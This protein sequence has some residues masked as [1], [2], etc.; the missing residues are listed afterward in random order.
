MADA[1]KSIFNKKATEKLRNPDDLDKY[2]RV[3]NPSV[4]VIL[5]ACVALLVG[6]LTWGMFGAV[7]TDVSTF[8]VVVDDKAVCFLSLDDISQVSVGDSATVGGE[9]LKVGDVSALPLSKNE[10]N[11]VLKS[12][13]LV[14]T[15]VKEDW[16]YQVTFVGDVTELVPGV[17]LKASITVDRVAPISLIV[18]NRG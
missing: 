2:M 16:V 5:G 6:L 7:T 11:K 14:S 9:M 18:E 4:W 12:D 17:P 1:T 8:A 13:Y 15:L 3:T 10:A